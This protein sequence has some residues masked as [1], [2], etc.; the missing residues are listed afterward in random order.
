MNS[1]IMFLSY[2]EAYGNSSY[3]GYTSPNT[4]VMNDLAQMTLK[5]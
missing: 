4:E 1:L 5:G 3:V 2:E